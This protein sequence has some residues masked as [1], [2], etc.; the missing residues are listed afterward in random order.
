MTEKGHLA[1]E[2]FFL[3]S[4][5]VS[6]WESLSP[7]CSAGRGLQDSPGSWPGLRLCA[8][9]PASIYPLGV[10]LVGFFLFCFKLGNKK[11]KIDLAYS[12]LVKKVCVHFTAVT[13]FLPCLYVY[14]L[15]SRLGSRFQLYVS[16]ERDYS[17]KKYLWL[18]SWEFTCVSV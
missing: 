2:C 5:T 17:S 8:N 14:Y 3:L 18:L 10:F 4:L 1:K 6:P 13:V 15:L 9:P 16:L 7:C 12:I 11:S